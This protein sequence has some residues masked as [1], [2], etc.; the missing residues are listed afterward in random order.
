MKKRKSKRHRRKN[1]RVIMIVMVLILLIAGTMFL[2][3]KQKPLA[4]GEVEKA[5][6]IPYHIDT[7]PESNKR[8]IE[9]RKIKYIVVHNTANPAS[10]ARNERDY[11]TNETNE[12]STSWHIAVDDKEMIEAVPLTE[13]AFHAGDGEGNEYGIGIEICESGD[14]KQAEENAAK[15]IAYLMKRY[16]I[17]LSRV[18]THQ[19]FSGKACP[20][21]LIDHWET[22]IADVKNNYEAANY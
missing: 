5:I 21:L 19:H 10:T 15:L 18:T 17:P 7:I 8:P 4:E 12:A 20:R 13:I 11:L 22:F 2:R 3:P 1:N 16:H 14:Y 6:G 9:N